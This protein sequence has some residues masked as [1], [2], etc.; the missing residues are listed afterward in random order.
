MAH[1]VIGVPP[2]LTLQPYQRD[3]DRR[4]NYSLASLA[5]GTAPLSYQWYLG[6]TPLTDG[7]RLSGH[8]QLRR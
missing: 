2:A 8:E 1:V 5:T 4:A 7:A 6:T 3:V